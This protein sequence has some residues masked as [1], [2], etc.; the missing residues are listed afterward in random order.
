MSYLTYRTP[1]PRHTYSRRPA[2]WCSRDDERKVWKQFH[3]IEKRYHCYVYRKVAT[4][5]V[6]VR[7]VCIF[8]ALLSIRCE[9][10]FAVIPQPPGV[11]S[12]VCVCMRVYICTY[13]MARFLSVRSNRRI[14]R[15]CPLLGC[16]SGMEIYWSH[17][18]ILAFGKARKYY[19]RSITMTDSRWRE[20]EII[21]LLM[22]WLKIP[23]AR[24]VP[25]QRVQAERRCARG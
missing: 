11:Q 13:H 1:S 17:Q 6:V 16:V 14:V 24:V 22:N 8:F 10:R 25:T 23:S 5:K 7:K 2:V 12:A 20:K 3:Q 15:Q 9:I 21:S 19:Y 18:Q 4:T